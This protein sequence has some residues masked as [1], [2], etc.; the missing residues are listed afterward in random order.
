MT[1][2]LNQ[3]KKLYQ[4]D[5]N[6]SFLTYGI[7]LEYAKTDDIEE[8]IQWLDK[9]LSLNADDCYSYFQKGKMLC[10]LGEDQQ[11]IQIL[12]TGITT[13]DRLGEAKASSELRELLASIED[14]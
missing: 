14:A 7:A 3:L 13:A 9:T 5:P 4:T 12:Q 11:A 10:E 2:R 1:D 6:D 8:A